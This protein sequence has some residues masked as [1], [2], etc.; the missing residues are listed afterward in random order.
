VMSTKKF[1]GTFSAAD[2]TAFP[3]LGTLAAEGARVGKVV[4]DFWGN[5]IE[6]DL[7]L[8]SAGDQADFREIQYQYTYVKCEA[9]PDAP[10]ESGVAETGS[11]TSADAGKPNVRDAGSDSGPS[12]ATPA[13]A[14]DEAEAGGGGCAIA[15]SRSASGATILALAALGAL[16]RRRRR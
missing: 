16:L 12:V 1:A 11:H 3:E 5:Q 7:S 9:G 15:S 6:D 8:V 4:L 2:A 10:K 13:A 14:A